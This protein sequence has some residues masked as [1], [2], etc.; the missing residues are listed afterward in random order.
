MNNISAHSKS[1]LCNNGEVAID[2]GFSL[3]PERTDFSPFL[4]TLQVMKAL[5]VF[6]DVFLLIINKLGF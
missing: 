1:P 5:E 6:I 2:T 3:F 4:V